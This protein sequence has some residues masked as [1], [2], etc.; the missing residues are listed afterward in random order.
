MLTEQELDA[1]DSSIEGSTNT[2]RLDEITSIVGMMDLDTTG[3]LS[4]SEWVFGYE[5]AVKAERGDPQQADMNA[6]DAC[7]YSFTPT[8]DCCGEGETGCSDIDP[9]QMTPPFLCEDHPSWP[10]TCPDAT[11][12]DN[13]L[14]GLSCNSPSPSECEQMY[15]ECYC[16]ATG[17]TIDNWG[18]EGPCEP[19]PSG[20]AYATNALRGACT[21]CDEYQASLGLL[22]HPNGGTHGFV[23]GDFEC[24]VHEELRIWRLSCEE[25][26]P[27]AVS[28]TACPVGAAASAPYTPAAPEEGSDTLNCGNGVFDETFGTC[29]CNT[30]DD[31]TT[32]E[33]EELKCWQTNRERSNR[34]PN[35]NIKVWCS[36]GLCDFDSDGNVVITSTAQEYVA[37]ASGYPGHDVLSPYARQLGVSV[38]TVYI[39]L[40]I[41]MVLLLCVSIPMH[42]AVAYPCQS[43]RLAD[44]L[45]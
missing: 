29:V 34:Y 44:M 25:G 41:G 13:P 33:V 39:V 36:V 12:Y 6:A 2:L 19:D 11:A 26:A 20:A 3:D 28:G 31:P 16:P 23:P 7:C 5:G 40:C 43:A 15:T 14:Y 45:R 32:P 10:S 9:T 8:G 35:G 38:Q 42:I 37:P 22:P 18:D 4:L 21:T 1:M 27:G 30:E 24:E 17:N